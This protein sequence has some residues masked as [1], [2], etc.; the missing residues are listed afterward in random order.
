MRKSSYLYQQ[1]LKPISQRI[2]RNPASIQHPVSNFGLPWDDSEKVLISFH[3]RQLTFSEGLIG[4]ANC[5][6]HLFIIHL[7][8]HMSINSSFY[9]LGVGL[10]H[11]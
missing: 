2:A 5:D 7:K 10:F 3:G 4:R 1:I 8:E 9:W 6:L 11:S